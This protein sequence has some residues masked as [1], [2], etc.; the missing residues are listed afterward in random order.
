[1][2]LFALGLTTPHIALEC[3]E[4]RLKS[5]GNFWKRA[6]PLSLN[7]FYR[8]DEFELDP[9]R[10][11]LSRNGTAIPLSSKAFEVLTYLVV[12]P[13]RVVTKDEL[14]KAVWPE[15]FVE[16]SN[17]PG[18]IS[19]LRKALTD[20]ASYIATVPGQGYQFTARVQTEALTDSLPDLHI[21]GM[22]ESTHIVIRETSSPVPATVQSRPLLRRWTSWALLAVAII[23]G[24]ATYC[25]FYL[26]SQPH[27]LSKVMV[28]DFLNLTGEPAFDHTLKNAL[29]IGLSQSP[30]I[31]LMGTGDEHS[32]LSMMQKAPD[33]PLLGDIAFE[34]CR[35]G[36]FQALLRGKI[37]PGDTW[38]YTL[39]LEVLN[40]ST[41]RTLAVL[42]GNAVTRDAVL[43]TLDGLAE[44]TR[45][46]VGESTQSVE[47]FDVPIQDASTFSFEGLQAFNTGSNLGNEGKLLECI[48]Y[49]QKAVDL[50]SK[51]AMAQA[52]LGTAY[53]NLGDRQK[54]AEYSK[55][56]FDLSGNISQEEKLFIRHNYYLMTLR[57]LEN[58]V[59]NLQE[60]TRL[61][62][63]DGTPW[64][65]LTGAEI[66][67][68]NF[69]AAIPA[70][71]QALRI[72]PAKP[73]LNYLLLSRA[74]MRAGRYA[75]A[76]RTVAQAQAQGKDDPD[77]HQLLLE[78]AFIEHDPQTIQSVIAWSRTQPQLYKTLETQ[79][80]LAADA[81]RYEES[82]ALFQRAMLDAAKE[83]EPGLADAMLIDEAGVEVE[84]GR[85]AKAKEL[86]D[87]VK[88]KSSIDAAIF[89]IKAGSTTAAEAYF[90]KPNEYP[91]D[92][93]LNYLLVPELKALQ[94]LRRNDPQSAIALLEPSIPYELAKPEVIEV[95]AQAYIAAHQGAKAQE[96]FQKLLDHPALED[97]T[98]PRT[99]L[100]HLGLA[101]ASA[102]QGRKEESR[103][104]YE[105]FFALWSDADADVPVLRQAHI[106]YAHL[107]E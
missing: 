23:A 89:E 17:L 26:R 63:R 11:S 65:A 44:R 24:A 6:M 98:M 43:N 49:F 62:P 15:S 102:M 105:T 95:R 14:L 31:Q 56:A 83:V 74:Y 70:G 92:T 91:H 82:E 79:A 40:C 107:Q 77:L 104:E 85:L 53:Y 60:W 47:Q 59:K 22:R 2:W 55:K 41:G 8:F 58:T 38:G 42:Q 90:K 32:A 100:A 94:A 69:S 54:A 9:S 46:K 33:T 106:E 29:E 67:L 88:D 86:L 45:G 64:A 39:S 1:V 103:K 72:N 48:P 16:E 12:N 99:S 35:R 51:F 71:E 50:D 52:S 18:Y 21:Q 20:R 13:G 101:R 76:K 34:V 30:Y 66:E 75:D 97:P 96:E 80:I 5:S 28:A 84:I 93:I 4:I 7:G 27:Q 81:G 73:E 68:G 61:Y 3:L 78:M 36:N 25:G 37:A 10:R 19:G 87:K 57:D